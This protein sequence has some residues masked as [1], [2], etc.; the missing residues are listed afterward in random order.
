MTLAFPTHFVAGLGP[1]YQGYPF[2]HSSAGVRPLRRSMWRAWLSTLGRD[3]FSALPR[4]RP[5]G[6]GKMGCRAPGP[7]SGANSQVGLFLG[8]VSQHG[9]WKDSCLGLKRPRGF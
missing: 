4:E 3:P 2:R 9:D 1:I 7:S 5:G 8:R 6:C